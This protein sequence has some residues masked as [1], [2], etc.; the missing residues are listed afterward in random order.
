MPPMD[1]G[2]LTRRG[3][4]LLLAVRGLA[5]GQ[6][7]DELLRHALARAVHQ[8]GDVELVDVEAERLHVV[9]GHQA[10]RH[11]VVVLR[12]VVGEA[13]ALHHDHAALVA[14]QRPDRE[15]RE[16][17]QHG[18]VEEQVAG[19]AEVA[20]LG[21]DRTLPH[22]GVG[23]HPEPALAQHLRGAGQHVLDRVAGGVR[24]VVRQPGEVA[25]GGRRPGPE[26]LPVAQRPRQDAADQRD[27]QQQVDRG[28]PR[29][30]E[31]REQLELLVDRR[32]LGVPL[33]PAGDRER[34]D[35]GLRDHRAGDRGQGEQEEQ[36]QRGAHRGELA[37]R[38]AQQ[39]AR[40][41]VLGGVR[42]R[43]RRG[44]H[45]GAGHQTLV[46]KPTMRCTCIQLTIQSH[47]PVTSSTPTRISITPPSR[48]TQAWWRRT[49]PNAPS[50]RR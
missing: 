15:A 37:P 26:A 31:D 39:L 23:D 50:A 18:Q 19:L 6:V 24:R 33:L 41:H 12:E 48:V 1:S 28:E 17:H 2:W 36:D 27:H 22:C 21:A 3:Y 11:E 9:G 38:P 30:V 47:Q 49:K 45:P 13:V 4:C 42:G 8:P 35:V 29:R 16:H 46:S 34:V 20:A 40:A 10:A 14:P 43:G 32:Q 25:R 44:R 7:G 5:V